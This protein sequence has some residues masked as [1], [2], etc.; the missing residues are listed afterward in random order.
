[1]TDLGLMPPSTVYGL[2]KGQSGS[3]DKYRGKQAAQM[4][5]GNDKQRKG[6]RGVRMELTQGT[7]PGS[8]SMN[9]TG[10]L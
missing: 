6:S 3:P 7:E 9:P 1:M 8:C 10:C 5:Y 2:L 4:K